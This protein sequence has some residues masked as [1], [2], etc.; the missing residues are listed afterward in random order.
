MKNTVFVVMLLL[1]S[2][3]AFGQQDRFNGLKTK[4]DDTSAKYHQVLDTA[5]VDFNSAENRVKYNAFNKR[6]QALAGKLHAETVN[7]ERRSKVIDITPEEI[8]DRRSRIESLVSELDA[9]K[10]EYD[11]WIR[12]VG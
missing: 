12:T 5:S 11:A 9:L 2:T 10:S 6:Y 8:Q 4:I 3:F 1:V 7:L